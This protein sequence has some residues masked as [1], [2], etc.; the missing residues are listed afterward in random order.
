M[1]RKCLNQIDYKTKM[2]QHD[3]HEAALGHMFMENEIPSQQQKTYN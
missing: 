2:C 1:F 3:K